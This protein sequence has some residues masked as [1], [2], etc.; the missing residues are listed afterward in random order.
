MLIELRHNDLVGMGAVIEKD[1]LDINSKMVFKLF[2]MPMKTDFPKELSPTIDAT[3]IFE[4]K[5]VDNSKM[6][7]Q[8][9][10]EKK[11]N[12]VVADDK[13]SE[14]IRKENVVKSNR[15]GSPEYCHIQELENKI[16][17]KKQSI[18]PIESLHQLIDHEKE[19]ESGLFENEIVISDDEEF[20]FSQSIM[21][22][23]KEDLEELDN[24]VICVSDDLKLGDELI[25][26]ESNEVFDSWR[27]M[28]TKS[29]IKLEEKPISNENSSH[30]QP[31]TLNW[32]YSQSDVLLCR[33]KTGF[34]TN[35]ETKPE[36]NSKLKVLES[37]K[38]CKIKDGISMA[39]KTR[40]SRKYDKNIEA[41]LVS[42]KSTNKK[43]KREK[44]LKS[45]GS[46]YSMEPSSSKSRESQTNIDNKKTSTKSKSPSK[47]KICDTK[48]KKKESRSK[49]RHSTEEKEQNEHKCRG[50]SSKTTDD[51]KTHFS[52][53]RTRSS[54]K[55][56]KDQSD[57]S[58]S[59]DKASGKRLET[60]ASSLDEKNRNT[61][62]L[63]KIE[64]IIDKTKTNKIQAPE[65]FKNSSLRRR[66][67]SLAASR[68]EIRS[69]KNNS[70]KFLINIHSTYIIKT[71]FSVPAPEPKKD[72]GACVDDL[73]KNTAS[74]VP[75]IKIR[76]L[77][78]SNISSSTTVEYVSPLES[79]TLD[80]K[81]KLATRKSV[82][83]NVAAEKVEFLK[84]AV[85]P[86]T[87]P[88]SHSKKPQFAHHVDKANDLLKLILGWNPEWFKTMKP[89]MN[90]VNPTL[91]PILNSF[92]SHNDYKK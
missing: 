60:R 40:S 20:M 19:I 73:S 50:S 2:E 85:P 47:P 62:I 13:A 39:V 48:K 7:I 58:K 33:K 56:A 79:P 6:D 28:N 91:I 32:M 64:I 23:V 17:L 84:P 51:L 55:E 37:E 41:E 75:P 29:S 74:V 24:D 65:P 72:K 83:F 89:E 27:Q 86:I 90:G 54:K 63:K 44:N 78:E 49:T 26:L 46:G 4:P 77:T 66:S 30:F 15:S 1:D 31:S 92:E 69:G 87:R 67:K 81:R 10:Q 11:L 53:S 8:S 5:S 12:D 45:K 38:A 57:K 22:K 68:L 18:A 35:I 88:Y 36:E 3:Q 43:G 59:K 9:K 52:R 25:C 80:L 16:D 71:F 14:E 42:E 76:R 70:T 21:N 34:D 61:N 82:R